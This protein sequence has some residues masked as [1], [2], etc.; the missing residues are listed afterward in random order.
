MRESSV[1]EQ[2]YQAVLSV[3]SDGLAIKQVA[4]KAGV[5]RQTMHSWSAR[6]RES[7]PGDGLHQHRRGRA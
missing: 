7:V 2:R 6:K 3:I 1:A 5:S 4:E